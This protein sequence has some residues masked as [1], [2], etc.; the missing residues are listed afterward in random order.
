MPI[1]AGTTF[2][3]GD[4]VYGGKWRLRGQEIVGLKEADPRRYVV[5]FPH[6]GGNYAWKSPEQTRLAHALIDAGADLY[7]SGEISEQTTHL[8]RE[9]GVPYLAAG[10]HATERYGVEALGAHLAGRFGLKVDF[11]DI[12]NP[13]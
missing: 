7:V 2:R 11:V 4:T 6:W 1:K 10:H 12:D 13:A 8:A 5:V 3:I 9:S